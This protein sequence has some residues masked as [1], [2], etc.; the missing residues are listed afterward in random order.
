MHKYKQLISLGIVFLGSMNFLNV[1]QAQD[2]LWDANW[3][4]ID[5]IERERMY[6][7]ESSEGRSDDP[8]QGAISWS[9][10]TGR[11]GWV[12]GYND[13]Y[14]AGKAA[15]QECGVSDCD[16]EVFYRFGALARE[17][18]NT[19]TFVSAQTQEEAAE[20]ALESCEVHIVTTYDTC[21]VLLIVGSKEGTIFQK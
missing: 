19:W 15:I 14:A 18:D 20:D 13:Y 16:R 2:L 3:R 9:D 6:G 4:E 1:A 12:W 5:R 8:V 10:S 17:S 21:E 11:Y 7:E